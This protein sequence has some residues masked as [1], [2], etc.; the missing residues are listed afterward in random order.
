MKIALLSTFL[1]LGGC[2]VGLSQNERLCRESVKSEHINP[3]T[4]E[5][6]EFGS[7]DRSQYISARS[8]ESADSISSQ[9][10][11]FDRSDVEQTTYGVVSE[12]VDKLKSPT[13]HT[14]RIK[15]DGKLGNKITSV[16]QCIVSEGTCSCSAT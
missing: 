11:D 2:G 16:M 8:K 14:L 12:N 4:V 13:F 15:A 6:Y 9:R 1:V 10:P 5:F 3:E 7:S